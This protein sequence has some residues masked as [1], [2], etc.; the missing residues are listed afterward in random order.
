MISLILGAMAW[1]NTPCEAV[2]GKEGLACIQEARKIGE[3]AKE[4]YQLAVKEFNTNWEATNRLA[5]EYNRLLLNTKTHTIRQFVDFIKQNILQP[6]SEQSLELQAS[7]LQHLEEYRAMALAAEHFVQDSTEAVMA[8][9]VTSQGAIGLA[10]LGVANRTSISR[11][12]TVAVENS[13]LARLGS[14]SLVIARRRVDLDSLVLNG[15]TVGSAFMVS[16]FVLAFEDREALLQAR[17][18]E[19]KVK[20]A[21]AKIEAAGDF[22]QQV[23]RRLNQLADLVY[24]LNTYASRGLNHLKSQ[25]FDMS[26][27]GSKIHQVW[28]AIEAIGEIMKLPILDSQGKLNPATA[29]IQI[30][31]H[32]LVATIYK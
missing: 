9:I 15:V 4:R 22:L 19:A 18:Y 28:L 21:I 1:G 8:R 6:A 3:R 24:Y 2:K 29:K 20:A 7:S 17:S 32:Q 10:L 25:L 5:A 16:G 12:S 14:D 26:R 31:Y 23:A 27:D 13:Q 30:K 11:L